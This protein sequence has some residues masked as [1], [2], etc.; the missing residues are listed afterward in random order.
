MKRRQAL[1]ATVQRIGRL[2]QLRWM[3]AEMRLP[4]DAAASELSDIEPVPFYVP[5]AMRGTVV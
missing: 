1:A 4:V 5:S 3:L 2:H